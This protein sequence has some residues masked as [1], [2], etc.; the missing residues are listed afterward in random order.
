MINNYLEYISQVTKLAEYHKAY[1]QDGKSLI[2]D[3]EYDALRK[4]LLQWE[5]ANPDQTLELSPTL[6]VGYLDKD[7]QQEEF[8]HDNPMLSLENALN[9]TQMQVW[10]TEWARLYGPEVEV[11]GEFK[12]DGI[13]IALRYLDGI[14]IRAL[15]RGDGEYG[16]DVTQHVAKFVPEQISINGAVEIRGEAIIKHSNLDWINSRDTPYA[17]CRS[18]VVGIVNPNRKDVSYNAAYV[19]FVPYDIEGAELVFDKYSQKLDVLKQLDFKMLSCF[20]ITPEKIQDIFVQVKSLRDNDTLGIDIDGIVYKINDIS[21]QTELGENSHSPRHAFAYKFPPITAECRITSVVFQVGRSGE[22]TPVAK[23]TATPLQGVVVTSVSLH[24]EEKMLERN[25]AVGH[26]YL[27]YRSGDVIPHLGKHIPSDTDSPPISF[28]TKC[29]S[30]ACQLVKRGAAWYC[31]NNTACHD[32]IKAAIAYAASVDV[33]NIE[34]MAEQT[35]SL[36]L[37]SNVIRCTADIFDLEMADIA[38]LNGFTDYSAKKLY[39]SIYAAKNTTFDKFIMALGIPEIGKSTAKKLGQKI[40]VRKAIFDLDTP[41]KVLE[42]KI[43]DVGLVTAN[44]IAKYFSDPKRRADAEALLKQLV[45]P[46]MGEAFPIPGIYAKSFV[47]TGRFQEARE[48]LENKVL[49]GGG[50]VTGS[51]SASTDYLVAGDKPGSKVNKARILN[52]EIIDERTFLSLFEN[53]HLK[54]FT[55]TIT[56]LIAENL[57]IAP[58]LDAS[59]PVVDYTKF[60]VD[61]KGLSIG[62]HYEGCETFELAGSIPLSMETLHDRRPLFLGNNVEDWSSDYLKNT[63]IRLYKINFVLPKQ[64]VFETYKEYQEVNPMWDETNRMY[65]YSKKLKKLLDEG[66]SMFSVGENERYELPESFI[67]NPTQYVKSIEKIL[68][69]GNF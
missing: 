51:V 3:G 18:A 63:P 19:S 7:R 29:P 34:N 42:L 32:Q 31:D 66:Y 24:N 5:S 22:V 69:F 52:V 12:Y 46:D 20:V 21:K 67:I 47:F 16:E 1:H 36:L 28:P 30:C 23:I 10:A 6:K 13:A 40:F 2:T 53:T 49:A 26:K 4:E 41:E 33:L 61:E 55:D 64:K 68:T 65:V 17:N 27:V 39:Y 58:I 25:I 50:R 48:L 44:N 35:V 15:T 8:R 56:D 54:D 11:I 38:A 45:V 57:A 59:I 60:E 9:E 14:F 43:P 37:R 62:Y